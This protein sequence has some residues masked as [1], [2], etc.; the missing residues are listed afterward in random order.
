LTGLLLTKFGGGVANNSL[1]SKK[2]GEVE[3][4]SGTISNLGSGTTYYVWIKAKSGKSISA[5]SPPASGIPKGVGV[6]TL[7]GRGGYADGTGTEAR[8]S[9]RG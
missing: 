2:W 8:F 9:G 6:S 5:F 3:G 4:L 7:A 1:S